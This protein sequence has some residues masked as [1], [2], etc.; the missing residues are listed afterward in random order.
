MNK[1]KTRLFISAF[2]TI[3]FTLSIHASNLGDNTELLLKEL[4]SKLANR[5]FYMNLK[6]KRVDSLQALFSET[7]PLQQQYELNRKIYD[8]YANYNAEL[9][10]E[11]IA[12]NKII[13]DSLKSTN[14]IIDYK[15]CYA[16]LLSTSGLIKE[17]IDIAESIELSDVPADMLA[18]YYETLSW[19]Y[20]KAGSFANDSVFAPSYMKK[21]NIYTDSAYVHTPSHSIKSLYLKGY[22]SMERSEIDEAE[23]ALLEVY[24][25][26]PVNSRIYAIVTY[27]LSNIYKEKGNRDKY[28]EFLI[29]AAISDQECALKE[30]L[31]LQLL[32]FYLYQYSPNNL[33]RAHKYIQTSMSDAQ[34]YNNRVRAVQIAQK[35]PIIVSAY[36]LKSDSEKNKLG[37]SLVVISILALFSI[38]TTIYIYGQIKALNNKQAELTKLNIQLTELNCSLQKANKTKEEYV[39]IFTDLCSSYIDQMDKYRKMVAHKIAANQISDLINT[40]KSS[41]KIDSVLSDFFHIFDKSF[42]NLYPNFIRDF[43]SLLI[44]GEEIVL[45]KGELLNP[46]LRIF[47][48]IRLGI[49]NSASIALFLRYSPQTI[50]NYRTKMR[51]K[52]KDRDSFEENIMKIDI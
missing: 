44:D 1:Q 23:T 22:I 39:S 16:E 50:Y 6:E 27:Y 41:E 15:L 32:A 13:A 33:E 24:E 43:N 28:E 48:L 20:R 5:E 9:A 10:S 49:S 25:R 40:V 14:Y 17:A 12:K 31:A 52:A 47:A 4:D 36:Q 29:R 8:E 2:T 18:D 11:Y 7:L 30:N 38:A 51:N 46:E 42:L 34:F 26:V 21:G 3:I 19:V 35:L 45:K 37:I